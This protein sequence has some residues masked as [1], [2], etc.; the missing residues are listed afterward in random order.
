MKYLGETFDIHTGGEDNIFPHHENE[1]AQSECAT[2]KKFVNY[3][4]HCRFLLVN[5]EKMSKSKSNFFTLRDL[6]TRGH[7][8]GAIRYFL[9]GGHYRNPLNLTE[10]ALQASQATVSKLDDFVGRV[11]ECPATGSDN[12]GLRQLCTQSG[13]E[14]ISYMD[15]DLNIPRALSVVFEF[16]RDVNVCL[17]ANSLSLE[18]KNQ[19]YGLFM[20][21]DNLLGPFSREREPVSEEIESL[22]KEREAVRKEKNFTRADDIR[23][24]LAERGVLLEDTKEGVRWRYCGP[25]Y[26]DKA[27]KGAKG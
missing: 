13:E 25:D 9:I 24:I 20:K 18:N 12:P 11:C 14:F 8:P 5:G 23:R 15:D 17:A 26:A 27:Q 19:I 1:I 7:S 6:I 2:G 21:W 16:I 10:E 4:L 22:I 3:W